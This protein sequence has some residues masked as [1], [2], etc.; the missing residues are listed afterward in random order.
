TYEWR[1]WTMPEIR[2][3]LAEAGFTVTVYL[4]EA[5]EDGD[6]NGVFYAS[7]HADADAAFLAYI[8]AER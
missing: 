6:G 5:D 4:E 2:E 7:D 1:L 3:M 8:V